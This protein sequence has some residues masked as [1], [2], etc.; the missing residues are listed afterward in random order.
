MG[1]PVAIVGANGQLGADLMRLW[2]ADPAGAGPRALTHADIEVSEIESVRA[3]LFPLA[4]GVVVNTSA[5]HRVD[6]IEAAPGCAFRVNVLGPRNLAVVCRQLDAV[7]VHLSTDYVFSGRKGGPYYESDP[8]DPINMYGI[9]K[10]AGEMAVRSLWRRHFIVR[11]SGLYGAAGPSGKGSNFVELMLRLARSGKPIRVVDDQT[12]TP[13][14]TASLARQIASLCRLGHYGTYHATCQGA[15]SW[16]E[17][18]AAIFEL[19]GLAPDLGRQSTSQSGAVAARPS[20]SVLENRN[21]AM[22]GIDRMPPW[23]HALQEYLEAGRSPDA[24]REASLAGRSH[25]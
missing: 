16:F 12:L 5:C 1:R 8:V 21:L 25:S 10:A 18:A 2:P 3:A 15:C 13:T 4:P 23:R 14:P 20:F 19:A 24:R 6:D 22:L 11:T 9:S 17:F 7:L